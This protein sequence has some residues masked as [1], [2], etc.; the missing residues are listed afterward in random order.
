MKMYTQTHNDDVILAYE[1]QKHLSN[2]S[3]KHGI[4]DYGK[5]K[6]MSIKKIEQT[7][8]ILCK[9]TDTLT[10]NMLKFIVLQTSLLS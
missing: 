10:T 2:A 8:S 7:E 4:V 5:L 3:H 9:I 6:K 1:F